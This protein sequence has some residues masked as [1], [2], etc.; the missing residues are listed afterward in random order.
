MHDTVNAFC[1]PHHE[2]FKGKGDEIE[3][4]TPT[5]PKK[6]SC[7]QRDVVAQITLSGR[8]LVKS[9]SRKALR[10]RPGRGGGTL[11]GLSSD[12]GDPRQEIVMGILVRT[13]TSGRRTAGEP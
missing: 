5:T 13:L 8:R 7:I 10:F 6:V 2:L 4:Q 3:Q 9:L 1:V 11:G 12:W